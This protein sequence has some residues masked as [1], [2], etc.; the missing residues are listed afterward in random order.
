[1]H[2]KA[3]I[4]EQLIN[5]FHDDPVEDR[6]IGVPERRAWTWENVGRYVI[7]TILAF[8]LTASVSLVVWAVGLGRADATNETQIRSNETQI[9]AV[10]DQSK[11]LRK[12]VDAKVSKD[13]F[14]QFAR[15]LDTRLQL[16]QRNTELLVR[17]GRER[18]LPNGVRRYTDLP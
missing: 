16:I 14:A 9:K 8:V 3:A 18:N 12:D 5:H 6:R 13:E 11:Q 15:D 7:P 2:F 10:V 17:Q 1:L 4:M